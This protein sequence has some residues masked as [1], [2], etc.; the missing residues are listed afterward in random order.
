MKKMKAEERV[1]NFIHI[2]V[3]GCVD[4]FAQNQG[5]GGAK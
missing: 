3:N 5:M 4:L 1:N 2:K